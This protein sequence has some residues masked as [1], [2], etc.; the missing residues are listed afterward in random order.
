[1]ALLVYRTKVHH[2]CTPHTFL[3]QGGSKCPL[4]SV[5]PGISLSLG[6]HADTRLLVVQR[7]AAKMLWAVEI[8]FS[9]LQG[10][11]SL[12]KESEKSVFSYCIL[13]VFKR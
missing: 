7:V 4:T 10:F 6:K 13:G 3:N 11:F 12:S 1:M 2:Y 5:V 8:L 9:L